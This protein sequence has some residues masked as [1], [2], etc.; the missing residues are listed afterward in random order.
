VLDL[1]TS[2]FQT[3]QVEKLKAETL[4]LKA[5]SQ[6]LKAETRAS[7]ARLGAEV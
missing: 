1:M 6:R 5:E 2:L 7:L 4:A 3:S